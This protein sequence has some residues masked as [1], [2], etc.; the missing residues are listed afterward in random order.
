M[1]RRSFLG[2]TAAAGGALCAT[3]VFTPWA[4]GAGQDNWPKLPPARIYVIYAGRTGDMYLA[5]PTDQLEKFAQYFTG[6]EKKFGDVKFIGGDLIP[7]ST[8]EQ[9]AGKVREAD[10][11]LIIH[12]S[13]HGGDA[14]VLGKLIEL[15]LPTVVFSQPFSGHGWMYFPQWHKQGKKV[16]LL[17]TSDW[18]EIDRAVGL[19]RVP[20]WLKQTRIIAWGDP[21]GSAAACSAEQIKKRL[22][23]ELISVR[24]DRIHQMMKDIDPK[25]AEAE[26]EEYWISKAKE[27]VEPKRPEI[28][29]SAKL[30]LAVK[31]LMI[32]EKAQ[33]ITSS[34]CMGDPRGCLT[35]SKLNDLGFVGACE[36]DMDSTLTMLMFAYAFRAPGFITDPVIDTA[37]NA[38]VHFHCT[39]ATKMDGVTGQRLPFVIRNQTDSKGGVALQVQ[40]RVGQPVTCAKFVNLDSMLITPGKILETSTSPLACR[41]QFAQS[42]PDARRLFL[43]WGENV[44]QGGV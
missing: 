38:M 28:I 29:E 9:L 32:Q 15:D 27:I 6:L 26:A 13:G 41:T 5:H 7:P 17:P 23:A 33:A 25:D 8:V 20:A 3:K 16:I 43:D 18:K 39:S 35:F 31:Q 10:G 42:V 1:T 19:L 4:F 2:T 14:P 44:I 24:N 30:Y 11:V 36:G 21:T 40:H 37:K 12:L 22:G 34:H